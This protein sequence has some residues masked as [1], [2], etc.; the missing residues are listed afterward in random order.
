MKRAFF[1]LRIL[2]S[3]ALTM[4]FLWIAFHDADPDELLHALFRLPLLWFFGLFTLQLF[5]HILRAV[6]WRYLLSPVKEN[7]PLHGAF[8]SLMIGLMINGIIPRAGEIARSYVL[9]K[10]EHIA[11]SSVLSTVILERLLDISSFAAV[12]C[13]VVIINAKSIVIWFPLFPGGALL[14]GAIGLLMLVFFVLLFLKSHIIFSSIKKIAVLFPA[15]SRKKID[16]LMDSF[17]KGFQAGGTRKNYG[18]IMLLTCSIWF[19]YIVLLFLP[20]RMFGMENLTLISAA[21]LQLASGMASAMPTPNG[22]GSYHSFI[23]FTLMRV[24]QV[25]EASAVAYV[26]Y[27]HAIGYLCTLLIGTAY[28]IKENIHFSDVMKAKTEE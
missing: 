19:S 10:R 13:I 20:M 1:Y 2:L 5:S 23:T 28:L 4:F 11:P 24:Y 3:M 22:I 26:V 8:S 15:S 27:T 12:L 17:L 18:I 25:T 7:I 9:G 6:R 16:S 21:T 14:L